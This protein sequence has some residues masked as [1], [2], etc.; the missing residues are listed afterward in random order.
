MCSL[1]LIGLLRVHP[2]REP[3]DSAGN[4]QDKQAN[5]NRSQ[6]NFGF[7]GSLP[8]KGFSRRAKNTATQAKLPVSEARPSG[9]PAHSRVALANARASDTIAN[10]NK[11]DDWCKQRG[12]INSSLV[13][14]PK[15]FRGGYSS[16]G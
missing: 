12:R 7:H 3:R 14:I 6:G 10:L 16:V 9:R 4:A 15:R 5:T 11:K 1:C 8:G 2:D 13:R